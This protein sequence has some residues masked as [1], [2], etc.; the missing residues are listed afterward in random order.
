MFVDRGCFVT[1][2]TMLCSL[3]VLM[4]GA[5]IHGRVSFLRGLSNSALLQG[6]L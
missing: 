5:L 4:E 1:E 2:E 3:C 6:K